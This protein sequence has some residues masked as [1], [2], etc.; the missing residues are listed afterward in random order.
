MSTQDTSHWP[1]KATVIGLNENSEVAEMEVDNIA[2][3]KFL[4]DQNY[5]FNINDAEDDGSITVI[6]M[7]IPAGTEVEDGYSE[8]RA[9]LKALDLD[10]EKVC[11][12]L[13]FTEVVG[14]SF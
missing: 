2:D 1:M 6:R 7:T 12:A 5:A 10:P 14:V 4:I 3:G 9:S 13:G 11:I 8:I